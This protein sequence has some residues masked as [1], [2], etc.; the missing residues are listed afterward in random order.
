MK[1]IAVVIILTVICFHNLL[2]FDSTENINV[3]PNSITFNHNYE[4][5]EARENIVTDHKTLYSSSEIIIEQSSHYRHEGNNHIW[6]PPV[7]C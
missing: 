5:D 2:E 4:T 1:K 3:F 6:K 7:N